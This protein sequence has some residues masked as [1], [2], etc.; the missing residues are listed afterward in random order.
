MKVLVRAAVEDNDDYRQD[1]SI[2]S[3][4]N[5]IYLIFNDKPNKA[6][7]AKW[8][9]AWDLYES[10][11]RH[12]DDNDLQAVISIISKVEK[13]KKQTERVI[14]KKREADPNHPVDTIEYI[15]DF[16][17]D[18]KHLTFRTFGASYSYQNTYILRNGTKIDIP[19]AKDAI[20]NGNISGDY[21]QKDDKVAEVL[22]SIGWFSRENLIKEFAK[23]YQGWSKEELVTELKSRDSN[24][25]KKAEDYSSTV[26]REWLAECDIGSQW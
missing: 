7:E 17:Y 24:R 18:G 20:S 9:K 11:Q 1:E 22:E 15:G 8:E 12:G 14:K 10:W 25:Y 23:Q 26:I 3:R 2:E 16:F 4:L 21:F 6:L 13:S 5:D 19:A